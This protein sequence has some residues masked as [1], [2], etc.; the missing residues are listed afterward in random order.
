[1]TFREFTGKN[2]EEAIRAAMAE[3]SA[4]LG[5]LDIEILAQGSRGILG[6]GG[7]EARILAAPPFSGRIYE[8][9][10]NVCVV[11]RAGSACVVTTSLGLGSGDFLPGYDVHLNSMLGEADL[12]PDGFHHWPCGVRMTSMMPR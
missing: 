10:T 6:V 4:D 5:D 2:V 8:H 9:T 12:S 7:E 1:M 11:D 3:F